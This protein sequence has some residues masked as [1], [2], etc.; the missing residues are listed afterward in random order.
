M[1]QE[2]NQPQEGTESSGKE[3]KKWVTPQLSKEDVEN[4]AGGPKGPFPLTENML[5]NSV[6]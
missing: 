3:L 5:Y 4:T 2:N 6:S 1:I